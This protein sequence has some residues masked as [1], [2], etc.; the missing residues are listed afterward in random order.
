MHAYGVREVQ[1]LLRLPLSTIRTLVHAGFV[2]PTRGP[3][4]AWQF[5][6]QDLIV[7]RTAQA[8][9]AAKVPPRRIARSMRQLR[10]HLPQS[11]PLSGLSIAAE[12]DRV[13]VREGASRWQA[14]SGQ[15]LLAFEGSPTDGSLTVLE[16]PPHTI[17]DADTFIERGY[18]LHEAGELQQAERTYREGIDAC[19]DDPVLLFNLA[20]VLEDMERKSDAVGAYERALSA[21]P[22]L[23]DCHYNLA[24][25]YEALAKPQDAIRHMAQYRRMTKKK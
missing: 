17:A 8:L 9:A 4:N 11:M 13:V 6:F 24:L 10:R 7:L 15:Y 16:R 2:S 25:L 1:K 14:D 12:A 21:D 18:A 22:T 3:R 23:A 5:S 20:V 19:G